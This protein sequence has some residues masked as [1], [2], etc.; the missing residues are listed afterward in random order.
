[1]CRQF[2]ACVGLMRYRC[3]MTSSVI[4]TR[5]CR[6]P[7][8][9]TCFDFSHFIILSQNTIIVCISNTGIFLKI[10]LGTTVLN[11]NSPVKNFLTYTLSYWIFI[12]GHTTFLPFLPKFK[13][14]FNSGTKAG[15]IPIDPQ[16]QDDGADGK[17]TEKIFISHFK[18][19]SY[20]FSNLGVGLSLY[21]FRYFLKYTFLELTSLDNL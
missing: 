13:F 5:Y 10:W 4:N 15:K 12:R 11:L 2:P 9:A 3:V 21:K 1:M 16:S 8:L 19:Y 17:R 6:R 20:V 7:R 14:S 18:Y